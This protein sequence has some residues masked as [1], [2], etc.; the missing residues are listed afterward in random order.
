[1]KA[2]LEFNLPEDGDDFIL[3]V[4]GSNWRH[5]CWEL[6]Q[7]LRKKVKYDDT[8]SDDKRE[9]YEG[10]RDELRQFMFDN[11]VDFDEVN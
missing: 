5:V 3:A 7:S 11:S 4:K 6:D 9:A 2:K 10:V 1:M 8:I